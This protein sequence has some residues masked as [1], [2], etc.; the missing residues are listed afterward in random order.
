MNRHEI[1]VIEQAVTIRDI[2]GLHHVEC[3]GS[4]C[5]CPIHHGKRLNFSFNDK[6]FHCFTCGESGGPIQLEA[7]LSGVSNDEAC[8]KIA[9]EFNLDITTK[10]WTEEDKANYALAKRIERDYEDYQEVLDNYYRK[11]SVLYR[12]IVGVYEL[13]DMSASLGE[14]LDDNINGVTQPWRY[15]NIQLRTS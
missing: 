12:N 3:H 1:D 11:L 5:R 13:A 6:L 4:R 15:Q 2:L 7:K 9:R 14:W 8:W 10:E